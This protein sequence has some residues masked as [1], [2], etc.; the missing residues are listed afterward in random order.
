MDQTY[1][2]QDDESHPESPRCCKA[3]IAASV[4]RRAQLHKEQKKIFTGVVD[5][6]QVGINQQYLYSSGEYLIFAWLFQ[7]KKVTC[8]R[9]LTAQDLSL[10]DSAQV[11]VRTGLVNNTTR[12]GSSRLE[13]LG[14][15]SPRVQGCL[16]PSPLESRSGL[17][18]SRL[19]NNTS[20]DWYHQPPWMHIQTI[21]GEYNCARA[22]PIEFVH[23][24]FFVIT[25][26][27]HRG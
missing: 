15:S 10:L 25:A 9:I 19:V 27:C 14:G 18:S 17:S 26:G 3:A 13:S 12:A 2:V 1:F 16:E 6:W 22:K 23:S 4:V 5:T 20:Q 8:T 11:P 7:R 24:A 21:H